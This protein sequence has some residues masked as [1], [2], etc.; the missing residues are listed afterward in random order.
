[1]QIINNVRVAFE[2]LAMLLQYVL[3]N[4]MLT[5]LKKVKPFTY[6]DDTKCIKTISLFDDTQ[7]T[8]TATLNRVQILNYSS[9]NQNLPHLLWP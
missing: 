6:A 8:L 5:D 7:V 3:L 9:I 1:M 4:Q 2:A